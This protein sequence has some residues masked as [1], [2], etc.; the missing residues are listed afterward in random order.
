MVSKEK[1]EVTLSKLF[2]TSFFVSLFMIGSGHVA[3]PVY[4]KKL[5]E[6][7]NWMTEKEMSD[8]LVISQCSPG[9]IAVN[10][11]VAI[12]YRLKGFAGV[13]A[14]VLGTILPPFILMIVIERF[15]S[16]LV[17]NPILQAAF[18][19][20]NI[21][22]AAVLVNVVISLVLDLKDNKLLSFTLLLISFALV[23]FFK[24]NVIFIVGGGIILALVYSL[25]EKK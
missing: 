20:M 12:G 22:V 8:I 17:N 16:L 5:V 4:Q 9:A 2:S 25:R 3:L 14:T 18:K 1:N 13:F 21:A 11:A 24:L 7:Y 19:G 6:D 10:M 23:Y 15:Y